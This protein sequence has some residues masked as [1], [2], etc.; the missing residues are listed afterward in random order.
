ML[1]SHTPAT[2]SVYDT[3]CHWARKTSTSFA[4]LRFAPSQRDELEDHSEDLIYRLKHWPDLP[5]ASRTADVLR[6]LSVMS[7]RPV[8]RGWIMSHSRLRARDVD[9]LLQ[10]LIAQDAVKIIDPSSYPRAASVH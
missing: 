6:T 3:L 1:T 8:N 7:T 4:E 5:C 10:R 9:R 2:P